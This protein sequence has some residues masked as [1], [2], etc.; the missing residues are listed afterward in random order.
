LLQKI[1]GT[2]EYPTSPALMTLVI[3]ASLERHSANVK[4]L[5]Y[6]IGF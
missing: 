3:L 2:P 6:P 4:T 5:S 1:A